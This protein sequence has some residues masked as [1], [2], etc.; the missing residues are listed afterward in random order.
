MIKAR[1]AW[2]ALRYA[3]SGAFCAGLNILIIYL[4]T[5]ILLI[6]Y[7]FSAIATCFITIPISYF[8][9]KWFT[10]KLDLKVVGKELF[11]FVLTQMTQFSLGVALM[12]LVVETAGVRPWVGMA[13]STAAL[14][15]LGFTL[16]STWVFNHLN[17]V[18][19]RGN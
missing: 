10:F 5:E 12:I 4:G 6:S 1:I 14:Y 17:R 19:G 15:V 11:K 3:I 9:H 7:V 2:S 18:K 8:L 16:N 13:L